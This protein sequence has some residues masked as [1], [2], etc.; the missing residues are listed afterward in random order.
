MC[1]Y[2]PSVVVVIIKFCTDCHS[3]IDRSLVNM[4]RQVSAWDKRLQELDAEDDGNCE[5]ASIKSQA[6]EYT[7]AT[8]IHGLKYIGEANRPYYERLTC[9][10]CNDQALIYIF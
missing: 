6:T 8:S 4:S 9:Y 2:S 7:D 1:A 3:A 5:L 10:L